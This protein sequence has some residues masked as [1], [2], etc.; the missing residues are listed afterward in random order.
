MSPKQKY[1]SEPPTRYTEFEGVKHNERGPDIHVAKGGGI[2]DHQIIAGWCKRD[3]AILNTK[4]DRDTLI[5]NKYNEIGERTIHR[6]ATPYTGGVWVDR[7]R[8][9][10]TGLY[11]LDI[12]RHTATIMH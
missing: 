4:T 11:L 1:T 8:P 12:L 9:Q 7:R 5:P 6:I 2:E 3:V 10:R